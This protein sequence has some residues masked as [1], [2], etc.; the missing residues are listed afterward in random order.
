MFFCGLFSWWINWDP[1]LVK[2]DSSGLRRRGCS[3]TDLHVCCWACRHFHFHRMDR[4]YVSV[5]LALPSSTCRAVRTLSLSPVLRVLSCFQRILMQSC[6]RSRLQRQGTL[7]LGRQR[8]PSAQDRKIDDLCFFSFSIWFGCSGSHERASLR[9]SGMKHTHTIHWLTSCRQFIQLFSW[10]SAKVDMEASETILR[11]LDPSNDYA[12]LC[13][14][15]FISSHHPLCTLCRHT[16]AADLMAECGRWCQTAAPPQ[17]KASPGGRSG[18]CGVHLS[19]SKSLRN[20]LHR[21]GRHKLL[22]RRNLSCCFWLES[23]L[24]FHQSSS[25]ST[26]DTIRD[27]KLLLLLREWICQ[28]V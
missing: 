13:V 20:R 19:P 16:V 11:G 9:S 7:S 25:D 6:W 18:D 14:F 23:P 2:C 5:L 17:P 27:G 4:G 24:R 10:S 12:A 8:A 28:K 15:A 3:C 26:P 22:V 21:D 1:R